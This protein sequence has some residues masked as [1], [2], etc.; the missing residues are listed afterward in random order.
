MAHRKSFRDGL[1]RK[2][3]GFSP[4]RQCPWHSP[5]T[6]L[7][8]FKVE[9]SIPNPTFKGHI[10][11]Q[12]VSRALESLFLN[13]RV[14]KKFKDVYEPCLPHCKAYNELLWQQI[15]SIAYYQTQVFRLKLN[16]TMMPQQHYKKLYG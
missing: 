8:T 14:F 13:S 1:K 5:Y 7:V 6:A 16:V 10:Y 4:N 3:L 11:F 15:A 9:K 2:Y 12:R